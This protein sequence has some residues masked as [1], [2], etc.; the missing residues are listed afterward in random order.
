MSELV[1]VLLM[2]VTFFAGLQLVGWAW[3]WRLEKPSVPRDTNADVQLSKFS[4]YPCD[5]NV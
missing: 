1:A 4:E 5:E 2:W 3:F